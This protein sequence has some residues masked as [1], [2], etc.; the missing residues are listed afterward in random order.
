MDGMA[1][2]ETLDPG[3]QRSP[4][5]PMMNIVNIVIGF[6]MKRQEIYIVK[7]VDVSMKMTANA[8][9]AVVLSPT[10]GRCG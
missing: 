5:L 10:V 9:L 4:L 2:L 3:G 1:R 8:T 6:S 7:Y